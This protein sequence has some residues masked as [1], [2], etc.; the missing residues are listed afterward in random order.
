MPLNIKR[1]GLLKLNEV[2]KGV[3]MLRMTDINSFYKL[4]LNN[5]NNEAIDIYFKL[6]GHNKQHKILLKSLGLKFN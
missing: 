6:T 3:Y 1:Y 5:Y 4:K 2:G